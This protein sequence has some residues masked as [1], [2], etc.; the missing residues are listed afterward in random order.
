MRWS[1]GLVLLLASCQGGEI[2]LTPIDF[3][4]EVTSPAYGAF[5]GDAPVLVEGRVSRTAAVVTVEGEEVDV[6][7]DGTFSVEL[8]VGYAY[9]NVD[10]A[11][12]LYGVERTERIPVFRG[13]D[14]ADTW[15]DG[16]TLRLGPEGLDNLGVMVGGMIDDL[17][18]DA[19]ILDALPVIETDVLN[20]VPVAVTHAPTVVELTPA[21]AGIDAAV[22]LRDVAIELSLE[23]PDLGL[24]VPVSVGYTE[25]DIGALAVP[26]VDD[27]GMV[28]LVLTDAVLDL[29]EPVVTVADLD[30]VLLELLMEAVSWPLE[31]M[32]ETLLTMVLDNFGVLELGGPFAFQTDLMGTSVD[33]RLSDLYGDL[34]GV[35]GALGLGLGEPAPVGPLPIPTPAELPPGAD[36]AVG[37]HEG[38]IQV[39]VAKAGLLDMLHQD[40]ELAGAMGEVLGSGIR[41]LPGGDDAP[42][43]GD[44]WCLAV[45]PG[46]AWVTRLQ[47]GTDPL[48]AIYLPDALVEI[49]VMD[50]SSCD[51]WL[52]ARV[53]LE[54]GLEVDGTALG[55]DLAVPE[56]VIV[57]YGAEGEDEEEV[58]A[59]LGTWLESV[60]GLLGGMMDL[61]LADLMGGGEL[62]ML[63]DIS[64]EV[65]DSRPLEGGP[66]GLYAVSLSLWE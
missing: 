13:H 42:D 8:P 59:A 22:S 1:A 47:E 65:V 17:G 40:I 46:T 58:I 49:G 39:M 45:D 30:G 29:Q 41:A 21:E 53:A 34:A 3:D 60:M 62:G 28:S 61:D 48:A 66:E 23:V 9:R 33:L 18:W 7:D 44:G 26:E 11:A 20:L 27:A 54:V 31:P 12:E 5:L 64:P 24:V 36:V 43:D 32:S 50:G 2:G 16:L 4:L 35:G 25:I 51:D 63:G 56:G 19:M 14:P 38:L 15:P 52:V 57:E 55:I 6:A 37:L 10:I